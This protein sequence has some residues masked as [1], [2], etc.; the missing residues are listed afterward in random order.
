MPLTEL[1]APV[2]ESSPVTR[3]LEKNGVCPYHCCYEV[4]DIDDAVAR[5]RRMRYVA[6]SKPVEAVA[7]Q[8]RRVCFLYNKKVGL[9]ELVESI[10]R[11]QV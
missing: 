11:K 1:L 4:D 8:G 3:I 9:I 7:L 2:D 10:N 5:L 6:T